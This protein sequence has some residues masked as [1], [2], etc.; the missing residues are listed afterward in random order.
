MILLSNYTMAS[1]SFITYDILILKF[2][3]NPGL[4]VTQNQTIP[5]LFDCSAYQSFQAFGGPY[6]QVLKVQTSRLRR[7]V[8]K[9][10]IACEITEGKG[11]WSISFSLRK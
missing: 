6:Q 9:V 7:I 8:P 10:L 5:P 11:I 2:Y 3:I 1:K 4:W